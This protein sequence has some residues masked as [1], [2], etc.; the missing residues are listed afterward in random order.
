MKNDQDS[1]KWLLV[2]AIVLLV[3]VAVV[4]IPKIRFGL[5]D[6]SRL[7]IDNW[8]EALS[9]MPDDSRIRV[10]EVLHNQVDLNFADENVPS[11]GAKIRMG[12]QK[13]VEVGSG[14]MVGDFIVDIPSIQ[15]SYR[16]RYFY[17]DDVGAVY[18]DFN[19][20]QE[21]EMSASV[22]AYCVTNPEDI[23]YPDFVCT[24]GN[25]MADTDTAVSAFYVSFLA[26][27]AE[28]LV[29][30]REVTLSMSYGDGVPR[31]DVIVDNC[32]DTEIAKKAKA[33]AKAWVE[34]VGFNPDTFTY[35]VPIKYDYCMIK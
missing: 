18:K 35:Y 17:G 22:V 4:V 25:V 6:S 28:I 11:S 1:K 7:K 24:D 12:S 30:D 34:S 8:S 32:G 33:A 26:A 21:F 20:G 14:L 31:L 10:E 13:S 23:I 16:I 9:Q 27:K 19:N 5:A 15:Q 2:A 3:L 29:D